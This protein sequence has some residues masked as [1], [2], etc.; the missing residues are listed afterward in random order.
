[1]YRA[2]CRA[3][4][5]GRVDKCR[6]PHAR[7]NGSLCA[8]NYRSIAAA[9][10]RDAFATHF[11]RQVIGRSDIFLNE[12]RQR[13]KH[14]LQ[15]AAGNIELFCFARQWRDKSH[16]F[17]ASRQR[18]VAPDGHAASNGYT[19]PTQSSNRRRRSFSSLNDGMPLTS[20]PPGRVCASK[21]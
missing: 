7:H 8:N 14:A 6:S 17:L 15:T 21:S 9:Q 18:N 19:T 5:R 16:R 12:K 20:R 2:G 4:S 1:M 11:D 3:C 10:N 13:V